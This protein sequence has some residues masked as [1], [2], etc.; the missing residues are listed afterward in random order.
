MCGIN[1][2]IHFETSRNIDQFQIIA[3]RDSMRHRG[4]DGA[5]LYVSK[6]VGL[7][8]RRLSIIDL[9]EAAAQPFTTTGGRYTIVFNGE[10][11]NYRE[12]KSDLLSDG[13]RFRSS[14]DTEIL[15]HLYI[16]YGNSCLDKLN[17]MFSFV[18]WDDVK[19]TLFC[20]RD[21]IGVKP[22]YYALYNNSFYFASEPKALFFAGV[23]ATVNKPALNELLLF[24]YVAGE[25]TTFKYVKRLLPG[26]FI[27]I[28]DA[29]IIFERWWNLPDKIKENR[30]NLPK[31]PFKWFEEIFYSSV[32]YRTISDV[33]VGLMLSGGLDSGS[34]A[35]ALS[36]LGQS[37]KAAFTVTF[38]ESGY[39]EGPLAEL[40]AN[41]FG[42]KYF[43]LSIKGNDLLDKIKEATWYHDEPLVHL[44]DAQMLALSQ[45]AKKYV[46]V[47]LSG[48]GSD[49]LMGG[50]VRYKPLQYYNLT[51]RFHF[52]VNILRYFKTTGFVNRLDKLVRYLKIPDVKAQVLL[53]ASVV[54]PQDLLEL[55]VKLNLEEF[56]YRQRTLKEAIDLYPNEPAR[57]AMYMDFFTHMA[58]VLDRNDRMT[59]G[60][61]IECR[62]PFMDY[63]LMEMIPALPSNILL[64]G[65]K[66]KY[67]LYNSVARH[68]P[69][70]VKKFK[71]VGFSVPWTKYLKENHITNDVNNIFKDGFIP[72]LFE[73]LDLKKVMIDFRN[74]KPAAIA[75]VPQ[76][77]MVEIW[78]QNYLDRFVSRQE[79]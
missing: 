69:E 70:Q 2:I 21:R 14:S 40:V 34:I 33:P 6:N 38:D 76:L 29:N 43:S 73:D 25:N 12:L 13:I 57:Q 11:F 56:E 18:I 46:S 30:E 55:N 59:M 61:G 44:N 7:G 28:K 8:H 4:P 58:S 67:L 50:Y 45:Y 41:K 1:G 16:K 65:K 39:N 19:K 9:S 53:N 36:K 26:Y 54:Y 42:L 79:Y 49:E 62:T 63:R 15:L 77:L 66:G 78:G 37:E 71:K 10:I 23:P 52:T 35:V 27:S 74:G 20:A 17:G 47:L 48:E 31:E 75:L 68:L 24:R 60:A 51:N 32:N 64:K 22:F 5:G 72:E 3:M